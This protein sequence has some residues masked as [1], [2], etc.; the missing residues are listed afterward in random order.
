MAKFIQ[1]D[2]SALWEADIDN[3]YFHP[4]RSICTLKENGH[5]HPTSSLW[6]L[7][8]KTRDGH[9]HP[10]SWF[11]TL[12]GDTPGWPHPSNQVVQIHVHGHWKSK[13]QNTCIKMPSQRLGN[14][15][16]VNTKW[17]LATFIHWLFKP[18][19]IY[20]FMGELFV[21]L[22]SHPQNSLKFSPLKVF[23]CTVVYTHTGT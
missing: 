11:C 23:C 9:F 3:G 5:F 1:Q 7:R 20:R 22:F 21:W 16:F 17:H 14:F 18:C 15:P 13:H 8:G 6:T 10:T 2:H 19:S 12:E 4:T